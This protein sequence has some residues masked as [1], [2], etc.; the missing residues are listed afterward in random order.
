MQKAQC[1]PASHH[2]LSIHCSNLSTITY[3][4]WKSW[5]TLLAIHTSIWSPF[6]NSK[7]ERNSQAI[8]C[9]THPTQG[10]GG[11]STNSSYS[12]TCSSTHTLREATSRLPTV[13]FKW[14]QWLSLAATVAFSRLFFFWGIQLGWEVVNSMMDAS[15]AAAMT[16]QQ[17]R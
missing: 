15:Q 10:G 9:V 11:G 5:L 17:T 4:N 3:S 16:I 8:V 14:C 13:T 2:N 6:T 7:Q 12:W 1:L